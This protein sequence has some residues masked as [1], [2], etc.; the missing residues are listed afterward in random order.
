VPC[1]APPRRKSYPLGLFG[2]AQRAVPASSSAKIKSCTH[3]CQRSPVCRGARLRRKDGGPSL[4]GGPGHVGFWRHVPTP[5]GCAGGAHPLTRRQ[6]TM[7]RPSARIKNKTPAV[8]DKKAAKER[9]IS[10][11]TVTNMF[12]FSCRSVSE[13]QKSRKTR[14]TRVVKKAIKN[15]AADENEDNRGH[16][17]AASE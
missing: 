7:P 1:Q 4:Q 12:L 14:P 9:E 13:A 8:T 16:V 11:G 6:M 2:G 5:G 15:S 17:L 10:R 3:G